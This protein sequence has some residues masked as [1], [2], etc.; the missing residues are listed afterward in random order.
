MDATLAALLLAEHAYTEALNAHHKGGTVHTRMR[1][2]E[3]VQGLAHA[4][5]AWTRLG[6]PG[7]GL[8]RAVVAAPVPVGPDPW[9]EPP[10][11]PCL[12]APVVDLDVSIDVDDVPVL[13]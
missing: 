9:A 6:E 1:L 4:R 12:V 11:P 10:E 2:D 5:D 13:P 3:A 8:A 7:L